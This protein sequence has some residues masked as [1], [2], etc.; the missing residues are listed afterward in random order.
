M[1]LAGIRR[2][3]Q[4]DHG[5]RPICPDADRVNHQRIAFIMADRIAVPRRRHLRRVRRIEAD[6]TDFMILIE[7]HHNSIGQLQHLHGHVL[8]QERH[9]LRPALVRR[10]GEGH[11]GERKIALLLD[12]RR[13]PGLQDRIGVVPDQLAIIAGA[14]IVA[15]PVGHRTGAGCRRHQPRQ[16]SMAPDAGEI[17]DRRRGAGSRGGSRRRL[18]RRRGASRRQGRQAKEPRPYHVHAV[19]P[20]GV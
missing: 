12:H 6:L 17:R 20:F 19:L 3:E 10:I 11:A 16:R 8:E 4:V 15:R 5:K 13:G 14:L 7:N 1:Q 18:L 2:A 9:R